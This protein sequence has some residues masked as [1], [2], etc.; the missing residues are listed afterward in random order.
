[1]Q[2]RGRGAPLRVVAL[3]LKA[4]WQNFFFFFHFLTKFLCNTHAMINTLRITL[5]AHTSHS[6]IYIIFAHVAK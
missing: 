6:R 5:T 2:L 4:Y 3:K 1:M